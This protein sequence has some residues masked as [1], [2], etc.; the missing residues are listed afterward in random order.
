MGAIV[1]NPLSRRNI[2]VYLAA[3]PSATIIVSVRRVGS[4]SRLGKTDIT[5][6]MRPWHLPSTR[7]VVPHAPPPSIPPPPPPSPYTNFSMGAHRRIPHWTTSSS[8]SSLSSSSSSWA[9]SRTPST[10]SSTSSTRTRARRRA[11]GARM[12]RMSHVAAGGAFF[13]RNDDY[14]EAAGRKEERRLRR[15]MRRMRQRLPSLRRVATTPLGDA[16][17]VDATMIAIDAA[18][19]NY[20][21]GRHRRCSI[22]GRDAAILLPRT[23]CFL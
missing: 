11:A 16:E 20:A 21:A 2:T 9:L 13:G 14:D 5:T 18:R 10:S 12:R 8:S 4:P 23:K 15:R 3:L 17:A 6:D 22:S 19:H 7:A 1:R